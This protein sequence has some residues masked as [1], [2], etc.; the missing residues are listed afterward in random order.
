M[1]IKLLVSRCGPEVNQNAG[2]VVEVSE[3]EGKRMIE[4][5]QA[6]PYA[7]KRKPETRRKTKADG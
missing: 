1:K 4:S 5:G 3:A 7:A 2:D 6:I